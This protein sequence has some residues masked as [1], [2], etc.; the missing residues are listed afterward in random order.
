VLSD[1]DVEEMARSRLGRT[2]RGKYRLERLI[3]VGG[4]AAVYAAVHRNG[5][6]VA[7]KLLHPALSSV[8]GVRERFLREGVAANAVGHPGAVAVLDDDVAED[9]SA[10]LVMELL[11]GESAEALSERL[12]RL[13]LP[14]VCAVGLQLL[15][16]LEAAHAHGIVH[17]DLKP[18]NL[19]VTRDG[20]LK[21]LDFGIARLKAPGT[22]SATQPGTMLGTPAFM[23][24]EQALGRTREVDAQTDIWAVGATLFTLASGREV[25]QAP[26]LEETL[27]LAATQAAPSL[28]SVLEAAPPAFVAVVD[29]ALAREKSAR[30]PSAAAMRAALATASA[31]LPTGPVALATL[32][33]LPAKGGPSEAEEHRPV[34]VVAPAVAVASVSSGSRRLTRRRVAIGAVAVLLLGALAIALRLGLARTP[35]E[36]AAVVAPRPSAASS[37]PAAH[38]PTASP[39]APPAVPTIVPDATLAT[40]ADRTEGTVRRPSTRP[41]SAI[42]AKSS[43]VPGGAERTPALRPKAGGTGAKPVAAPKKPGCNPPYRVDASGVKLWK[44]ECF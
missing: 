12:G 41:D 44:R 33:A 8:T 3:G 6:N 31:G 23:A 42:A 30:W 16:V 27:V 13:P 28:S 37:A 39:A 25:H 19:L 15:D 7:V 38:P 24:P 14:T 20:Q 43:V 10:F 4:M 5:R 17:R 21:V 29:R 11:D 1:R 18:A 32:Y 40:A 22:A 34:S 9:G 36:P 35:D 2:L 26:A